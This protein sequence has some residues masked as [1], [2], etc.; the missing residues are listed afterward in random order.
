MWYITS[1]WLFVVSLF[2]SNRLAKKRVNG[3]A[4]IMAQ[5]V[6]NQPRMCLLGVSSKMVTPTPNSPQI[7]KNFALRKPL[8]A[9]NMHKSC[10]KR[11]QNSYSNSKQPVGV[12][13]FG[14]KIWPEVVL[15]PFL[16][17]RSGK[18]AK[19]YLK[20]WSNFKISRHIGNRAQRVRMWS[21]ILHRK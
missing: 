2:S 4:R 11:H 14:L 8:F 18:L 16:R 15:W 1:L 13:N 20:L 10:S 12:S 5:N 6:W 9:Q 3:F 21:Q 19:K 7:S 17:M